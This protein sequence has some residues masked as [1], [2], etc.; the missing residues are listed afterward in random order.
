VA[1]LTAPVLAQ[2]SGNAVT[3][4]NL[5]AASTLVALPP[6]AGGA[7]PALQIDMA[8]TQGA[9]YDAVN[10]IT[11]KHHRPYLLQRRFSARA[12][13]Q[14]AVATAAYRVLSHIVAT[15][16]ESIPFPNR[17]ALSDALHTAYRNA[18]STIPKSSFKRQ[19]KAAGKA[20]ADAMIAARQDDG[21]FGPSPWMPNGAAGHW[22]PLLNADGSQAL[23]P[24]P[25]VGEVKPFLMQSASQFRTDGPLP[26]GSAAWAADFNE[27][28]SLGRA[29]SA[30]RTPDQTHI[31]RFWQ[32]N[33]PPTWNAV[34]RSLVEDPSNGIGLVD[35]ARLFAMQNLAAADAAINCWNDKYHF[36]FW[37][38]WNAIA[39]GVDDGNALT[40]ADST[41]TALITAP[42]PEHPSGHLCL[43][44]AHTA[45]LEMWFGDETRFGVTSAPFPGEVRT[46]DRFSQAVDEIIEARIWAGSTERPTSR[47]GNL[48]GTWRNTWWK[49]FHRVGAGSSRAGT[50]K[51]LMMG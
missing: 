2:P 39:G 37:R 21:R 41:W 44:G 14:A 24:T 40:E 17:G 22:Q 30:V 16:P 25:W 1:G 7:P 29:D 35:S 20:A 32:S 43:D 49:F 4:W 9:V 10:A 13:K 38:P 47:R 50:G 5:I 19:G 48:A 33:V 26:L 12:S 45:V 34:T 46:Y 36:D 6:R 11:P 18:L 3:A 27:V 51:H 23:E 42:Y 31:A 15:V 28:K 8:M